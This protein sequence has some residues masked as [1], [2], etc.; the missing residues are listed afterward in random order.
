MS[1]WNDL[2]RDR[3]ITEYRKYPCLW[4]IK[5]GDAKNAEKRKESLNMITAEL[6]KYEE[7]QLFTQ[8]EVRTQFKNLRDM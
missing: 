8:D 6:N 7:K 4:S 3:L 2:S 5:D 1:N